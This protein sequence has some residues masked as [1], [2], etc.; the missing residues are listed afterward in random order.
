MRIISV[1][2]CSVYPNL[3]MS[4]IGGSNNLPEMSWK[5]AAVC[6]AVG[7]GV[8]VG[9]AAAIPTVILPAIGFGAAGV[10]GGSAAALAQATIGNVAAGS[11]FASL[12]SAGAVGAVSWVTTGVTTGLGTAAGAATG[13]IGSWLRGVSMRSSIRI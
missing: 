12:Q 3:A 7:T 4:M 6:A 5:K 10:V 9:V 13:A 2:I 8:G 11:V 1:S